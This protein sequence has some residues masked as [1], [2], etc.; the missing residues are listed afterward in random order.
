MDNPSDPEEIYFPTH[1]EG[2]KIEF[3]SP[4]LEEQGLPALHI[5]EEPFESPYRTPEVW[6]EY[7]LNA[8]SRVHRW[9]GF[10]QYNLCSDGGVGSDL[11]RE[12]FEMADPP[13]AELSPRA[14]EKYR[15]KED[16]MIWI[17]TR[18]GKVKCR[19]FISRRIPDWMVVTPYHRN[20][21][22]E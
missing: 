18:Y 8:H 20:G 4:W 15:L 16:D 22:S 19:L 13:S 17:E 14:A 7:P 9:W 6:A 2:G 12:V 5:H 1:N 11:L 21:L 10:L 3:E